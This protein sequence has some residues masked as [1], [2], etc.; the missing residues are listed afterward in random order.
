MRATTRLTSTAAVVALV[1]PVAAA[2]Q[3]AP[4]SG[5]QTGTVT[6]EGTVEKVSP[7]FVQLRTTDGTTQ[8]FRLLEKTFVHGADPN[9]ELI[10][11]RQGTLVAIHYSGS[12]AAATAQ[13]VDRIDAAG[14]RI[15]EGRVTSI[16]RDRGEIKVTFDNGKS[17]TFKLTNRVTGEIGRDLTKDDHPRVIVYYTNNRGVKEVHYFKKK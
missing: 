12:G 1:L 16:N 4:P 5:L 10:G 2:G 6:I 7:E 11:L 15:S 14:L 17:E 3:V 13:E 9:D 8:L